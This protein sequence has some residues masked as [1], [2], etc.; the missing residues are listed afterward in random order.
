METTNV[1]TQID[2]RRKRT[3]NI[4]IGI[5]DVRSIDTHYGLIYIKPFVAFDCKIEACCL[6]QVGWQRHPSPN[7]KLY[8]NFQ[9]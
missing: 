2:V 6:L 9:I 4:S 8:L 7:R 5:E 1:R 3:I